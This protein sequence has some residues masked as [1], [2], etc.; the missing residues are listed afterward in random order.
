MNAALERKETLSKIAAEEK[1]KHLQALKEVEDAKNLLD[2]E[3]YERKI[4]ELK[5]LKESSEKQKIVD[6]LLYNDR[7]YRR[8]TE[9]E[10]K[11]ATDFFSENSV[12]GEGKYGKVYKCNIDHTPVA[13]KV[14]WPDAVS[15][16]NEFL[17]EVILAQHC[18]FNNHKEKASLFYYAY[19]YDY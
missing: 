15:K 18:F 6:A 2:K 5:A 12:I 8:Y 10:I 3:V 16:K 7:R 19:H 4:A 13:V 14:L 1:A 11:I 9:D 17:K